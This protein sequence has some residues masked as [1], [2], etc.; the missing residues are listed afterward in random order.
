VRK[1]VGALYAFPL[2]IWITLFFVLPIT[3]IGVYSFL[4]RGLYGGVVLRF[5]FEAYREL[6]NA[7]LLHTAFTTF[8]LA[9][10][11]TVITLGLALPAAYYIACSSHRN[12]LLMLVIIPFWTNFLIRIYAW[13]AILGNNGFLNSLLLRTGLV[14]AYAHFLYNKYAVVIVLMYT[15]LPYAVLPLYSAIEKFD[16]SLLE[17][18]RDLGATKSQALFRVLIPN[19]RA[20]ITTAV[21]FT[22]IPAFGQYAVPQLVGGRDS[23]MLGTVIARELTVSRNWPLASA[24]AA[25]LTVLTTLSVLAFMRFNRSTGEAIREG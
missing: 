12:T 24:I 4:A 2:G 1:N 6:F 3:V 7:S 5:S 13:I 17:A 14:P 11:A 20:G 23:Y 21:L 19:I 8:C 22:F 25:A 9:A 18:A 10:T 16:F 15:Y